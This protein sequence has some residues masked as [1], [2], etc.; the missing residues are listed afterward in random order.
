MARQ[1]HS[2]S[3][4]EEDQTISYYHSIAYYDTRGGRK[5]MY[6]ALKWH[7]NIIMY[8][9]RTGVN[10]IGRVVSCQVVV[11]VVVSGS[12]QCRETERTTRTGRKEV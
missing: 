1:L 10:P 5:I 9:H 6:S 2:K 8:H 12:N 4:H 3:S 7:S 11:V